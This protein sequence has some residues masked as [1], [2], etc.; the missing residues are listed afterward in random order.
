MKRIA[1][2][3][4][5]GGVGKTTT[6]ANLGAALARAGHSVLLV[7]LDPQAH[8]SLHLGVD[9]QAD[10]GNTYA[11]LAHGKPVSM[12][13]QLLG[14]QLWIIPAHEDLA[15]AETELISVIGRE[16]ILRDALAGDDCDF[17]FVL[18]DCPP[19]LGILTLN[20]L[21]AASDVIIPMQAHFL[22][23]Q[24]VGK[25][26]ETV[27]LVQA[28][29]NPQIQVAGVLLCMYESSTRL[30]SEVIE[31]LRGFF[32]N[33]RTGQTP[34]R[35]ARVFDTVIRRNIKLAE[36]PSHGMSV[37][38]YAPKSHGALDYAA[39][40]AEVLAWCASSASAAP[41]VRLAGTTIAQADRPPG[42][43][44]APP[45]GSSA[46]ERPGDVTPP[47]AHSA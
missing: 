14:S 41:P 46:S 35:R 21:C 34:W 33:A 3:N 20:G 5:K 31:D 38:D 19:S 32:G 39:L 29:I 13:R 47:M 12:T 8:L 24:G 16:I 36:S 22:A 17:D 25:L 7:D 37:L 28:R 43:A 42:E 4:Q 10:G 11:L 44:G 30:G 6:T 2:I 27:Q 23:L 40:A 9:P 1:V 18:I 26:L 45:T 15:A